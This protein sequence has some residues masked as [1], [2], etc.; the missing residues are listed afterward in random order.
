MGLLDGCR[1][2]HVILH[3]QDA[4]GVTWRTLN[5]FGLSREDCLHV[6][7]VFAAYQANSRLTASTYFR[8]QSGSPWSAR[9]LAWPGSYELSGARREPSAISTWANWI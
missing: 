8:M 4:A 6:F 1:V 2:Q 7:K 5:R 3:V 9:A